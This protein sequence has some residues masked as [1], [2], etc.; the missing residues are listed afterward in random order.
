MGMTIFKIR[1]HVNAEI[2]KILYKI[3]FGS[4]FWSGGVLHLEAISMY[5]LNMALRLRLEKTA[6]LIMIVP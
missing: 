2:K 3:V 6:S 5:I 1:W 4:R